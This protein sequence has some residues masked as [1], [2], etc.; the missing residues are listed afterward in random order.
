M[1]E[2]QRA[3]HL[4]ARALAR[5]AYSPWDFQPFTDA[6]LQYV[7]SEAARGERARALE[8]RGRPPTF[9]QRLT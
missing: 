1:L 5:G 6:S 9:G 7:R 2:S 3:R 8:A 4:V